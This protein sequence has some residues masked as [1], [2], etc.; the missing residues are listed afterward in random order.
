[1]T[2]FK[3]IFIPLLVIQVFFFCQSLRSQAVSDSIKIVKG[4]IGYDYIFHGKKFYFINLGDIIKSNTSATKYYRHAS[5]NRTTGNIFLGIG[6]ISLLYSS[7]SQ[8][9]TRDSELILK[10]IYI[11][12][13]VGGTMMLISIPFKLSSKKQLKD[14]IDTYN[15]GLGKTAS[16]KIKTQIGLTSTGPSIIVRF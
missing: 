16:S 5:F 11:G 15:A 8:L 2:K 7:V 10:S 13:L 14:A 4:K 6:I 9:E 12:A 1:M 3:V